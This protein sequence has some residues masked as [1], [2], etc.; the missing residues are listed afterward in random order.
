M[1]FASILK[2]IRSRNT[3]NIIQHV[4]YF[5][6]RI[7]YSINLLFP[8]RNNRVVFSSF[9]GRGYGGNPK[10]LAEALRKE[11][12]YE[13]I[14][15][16]R[17]GVRDDTPEDIKAVNIMSLTGFYYMAT[18]KVWVSDN[19]QPYYVIKRKRQHYLH[20]WHGCLGVKHIEKDIDMPSFY[21]RQS[22]HDSKMIDLM[23]VNSKKSKEI[24]D[25]C[26]WY[27]GEYYYGGAPR[28]DIFFSSHQESVIKKVREFYRI[29]EDERIFVYVPSYRTIDDLSPYRMDYDLVL[30]GLQKKFG[31]KWRI[32]VRL[33]PALS[34]KKLDI[35]SYVI[36]ATKYPDVQEILLAASICV[37]DYSSCIFDF[38]LKEE[39]GFIYATDYEEMRREK[40]MYIDPRNTP[41]PYADSSKRLYENIVNFDE[42]K[43]R[44]RLRSYFIEIGLSEKGTATADLTSII[45]KWLGE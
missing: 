7:I 18:A 11:K 31:G 34:D 5:G 33:H 20:T 4:C 6:A 1:D 39:P 42:K 21:R 36:D 15:M 24:F 27:S 13:L 16:L 2:K 9:N 40:G 43:Y 38:M 26:F 32:I 8:I 12:K 22:K 3:K 14:W 28:N 19:R 44:E 30:S 23:V 35:P 17:P 41:F 37:T 45:E 25:R 29:E 10:C